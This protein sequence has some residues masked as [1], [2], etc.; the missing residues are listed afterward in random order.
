MA[1]EEEIRQSV[2]AIVSDMIPLTIQWAKV[3]SI[4]LSNGTMTAI[5]LEDD[6]PF[7]D[8][9]LNINTTGILTIPTIG[10]KVL[11]G[12]VENSD[13]NALLLMAEEIDSYLI[14]V[15]NGFKLHLKDDGTAT[16]NGDGFGGLTK[17]PE[18]VKQ[19]NKNN[20]VL[21]ALI[22]VINSPAPIPEPGSGSPSALQAAF[23]TAIS[24]KTLGNFSNV[25]NKKIKHG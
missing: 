10:T 22:G 8:V 16:I 12:M 2:R 20:A 15:K 5:G 3:D 21:S 4:D 19:L 13:M 23:K 7:E 14:T 1:F 24:G 11:I 25:E 17:T 18:L 9:L 6:L